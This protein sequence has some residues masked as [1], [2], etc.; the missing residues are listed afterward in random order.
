MDLAGQA[1]SGLSVEYTFQH[2]DRPAVELAVG[3]AIPEDQEPE[4]NLAAQIV[5]VR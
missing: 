2:E 3:A 5:E 1:R 4:D